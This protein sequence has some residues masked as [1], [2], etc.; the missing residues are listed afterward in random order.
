MKKP[1]PTV[2]QTLYSLNTGNAH[3]GRPQVLTPVIVKSVGRKYFSAG[4]PKYN[5]STQYHL[6]DWREKTEYGHDS[7]VYASAQEWEDE[8]EAQALS[9]RIR[10]HFQ[11]GQSGL[12]L[13]SLRTI[14][15][16]LPAQP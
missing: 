14:A 16:F 5:I 9:D 15:E 13:S 3:R 11:Y 12:P 10:K 2:G 1:I 4:D 7:K 6:D 8:K